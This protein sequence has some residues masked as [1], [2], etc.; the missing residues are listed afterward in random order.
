MAEHGGLMVRGDLERAKG[1]EPSTPTL[2]RSCSTP[3]LHPHP[4]RLSSDRHRRPADLCQKRPANATAR[5]RLKSA[6][7]VR[8]CRVMAKSD[9]NLP[10]ARNFRATRLSRPREGSRGNRLKFPAK[11]PFGGENA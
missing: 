4:L 8:N 5:W 6:K 2:A 3:E 7:S 11:P 1:F 10:C 9:R